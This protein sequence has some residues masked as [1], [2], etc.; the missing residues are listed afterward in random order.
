VDGGEPAVG[1][2]NGP[3]QLLGRCRSSPGISD[4]IDSNVVTSRTFFSTVLECLVFFEIATTSPKYC[5]KVCK[6]VRIAII[7]LGGVSY[8]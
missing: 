3:S 8:S 7:N 1:Q 6:D 4:C 5:F 2:R